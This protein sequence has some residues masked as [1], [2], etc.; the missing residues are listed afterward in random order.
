VTTPDIDGA[1]ESLLDYLKRSRGFDFTGYKRPSLVRRASRRMHAA[2]VETYS[3][4]IDYLEVH[5]DEFGHLF[6]T[7]LIN[8]TSF[9]R[10]P[11]VWEYLQSTIIPRITSGLAPDQPLRVWSV[12][13]AS[14]EEAFTLAM[15]LAEVLGTEQ[16]HQR[17]KI[18]ATDVDDEALGHGRT[19]SYSPREIAGVSEELLGRYFERTDGRFVFRKD[20][21]RR[22][23]FGRHDLI[24]DAPISRVDLILCRNT[25]MYFNAETQAQIASRL[26]FALNDGRI[27]VLGR[28]E[29]LFA[30]STLFHPLDLKRRIFMKV[31]R[32]NPRD[33]FT[34]L[35]PNGGDGP[36]PSQARLHE[37]AFQTSPVAQVIVDAGGH[38][39]LISERARAMFGLALRD[40]GSRLQDLD[41][42]YRPVELRSCID[43]A[44]AER[45]TIYVKETAWLAP[46][47]DTRWLD[48]QVVPLLSLSDAILGVCILFNDVTRQHRLQEELEHSHQEL[49]TAYEELQSTNEELETTN[50]ELQSTVEELETTN[51]ELQSTN[52]ELETTNEEMQSTNEEL[53]STNEELRRQSDEVTRGNIFLES[54]LASMRGGVVVVDRDLSVLA[55]NRQSEELWGLRP[56]EAGR[57]NFLNLEIGLPV[58]QLRDP[59]RACLAGESS[60]KAVTL[61]AVSRRGRL[62]QCSV[63]CTPLVNLRGEVH[64]ALLVVDEVDSGSSG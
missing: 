59:I 41:L 57:R 15:V 54:I 58:E 18:Y 60:R 49:E 50:E 22:V 46:T 40:Q 19:A 4:Y 12:G 28:A 55:W 61:Q 8:V 20:L 24:Q 47:G 37:S 13:C 27:L 29:M 52:E 1:F 30:Q 53:L 26:H 7:I 48:I 62:L 64:G 63:V 43:Q 36:E 14:G 25:L 10:D 6:N 31:P 23:I 3:D 51:E 38:A 9:F 35:V 32:G 39:V 44:V 2:G 42:S 17:V 45:R 11:P 34:Y 16:F 21:R 5:P 33:R 56:E